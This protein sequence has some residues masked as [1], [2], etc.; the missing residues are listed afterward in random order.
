MGTK[1]KYVFLTLNHH[2]TASYH[3]QW[4]ITQIPEVFLAW[5]TKWT[6]RCLPLGLDVHRG[7]FICAYVLLSCDCSQ[8]GWP[9]GK[10]SRQH[11][12]QWG[13]GSVVV[14]SHK[15]PGG[16]RSNAVW[17]RIR[18]RSGQNWSLTLR[19]WLQ[20]PRSLFPVHQPARHSALVQCREGLRKVC[21]H[22]HAHTEPL[23]RAA[24]RANLVLRGPI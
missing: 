4:G 15:E 22:R 17:Q 20:S 9:F 1:T 14:L 18:S 19:F 5:A 10:F 3:T 2:I 8:S 23:P 12:I 21:S 6:D 13:G 11:L 16:Q 7:V 24:V